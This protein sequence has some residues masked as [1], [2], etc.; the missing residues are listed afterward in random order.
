MRYLS[1]LSILGCDVSRPLL[2]EATGAGPVVCTEMPDLGWLRSDAIECAFAMFVLEHMPHLDSLVTELARVVRPGGRLVVIGN[3][4]AYT[5]PGS[6]PILDERDGEVLWRWGPYLN[7]AV[8]EEPVGPA[9]V[10]L[11]HRSLGDL[12]TTFATA[13]WSLE[14]FA[15]RALTDRAVARSPSLLGQEH[16]PRMFG[17]VWRNGTASG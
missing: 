16:F 1:G 5:A 6:G 8:S 11:H 4:P 10:T 15:E 12:L 13:G 14:S 7:D 3:H 2:A 17:A 9:K